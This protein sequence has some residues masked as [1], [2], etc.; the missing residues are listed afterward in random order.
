MVLVNW[1][2]TT[3]QV[4]TL[5]VGLCGLISAGITAY[6]AIKNFVK[7]LKDK[8][9]TEIWSLV[10]NMADEAIKKAEETHASGADKKAM[11]I[12]AVKAACEEANIDCTDF[13]DQLSSYIDSTIEFV[14]RMKQASKKED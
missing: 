6:F 5:I 14:N 8:K 9:A 10:M 2:D 1:L 13:L 3:Q 7:G 12:E 4:I 11:V